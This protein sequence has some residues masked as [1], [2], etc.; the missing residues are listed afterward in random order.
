LIVFAALG[1][2]LALPYLVLSF[3]PALQRV[4][5]RPGAW[6][7][8]FKQLLAFPMFGAAVWLVW[9][10]GV[11][12]G[13]SA[14][15]GL[16][17]G[18]VLLSFAIWVL[19]HVPK[20]GVL[21]R[22]VMVLAVLSL[23][24]AV[25]FIPKNLRMADSPALFG[26]YEDGKFGEVFSQERLEDVL[27]GDAPVFVEMTAAWCITCKVNHAVAIN[28]NS[29]KAL[30]AQRG[31]VYLIGDWTNEDPVITR[32]L[33]KYGRNGVPLYVYY[34]DRDA[35]TGERPEPIVMPQILTPAVVRDYV[36]V[37]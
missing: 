28:V 20:A 19:Q 29:T 9:I 10:L 24:A 15:G 21:R 12:V 23:I 27:V 37:K 22:L 3:V 30:F 35:Q 6:M 8:V 32:Y 36:D 2:G 14:M 34:G 7:D 5:P 33:E 25:W 1:L 31:V 26:A 18:A 17:V 16:L 4:M 13:A 11:Q